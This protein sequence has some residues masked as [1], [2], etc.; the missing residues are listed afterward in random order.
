EVEELVE[1]WQPEPL[2]PTITENQRVELEK[3]PI[4]N[5]PQGPKVKLVNCKN[6]LINL[7]SFDFLGL[8]TNQLIKEKAIQI[9]RKYGVGSCGPPG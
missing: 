3:F 9:L 1:E 6:S 4:L 2:V 5:G 8:T 7:A